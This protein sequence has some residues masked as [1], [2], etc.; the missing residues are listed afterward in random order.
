MVRREPCYLFS[1]ITVSRAHIGGSQLARTVL[2]P[3]SSRMLSDCFII[4]CGRNLH[5]SADFCLITLIIRADGCQGPAA[6]RCA[7]PLTG[8]WT[9][10]T[11]CR[12]FSCI[13]RHHSPHKTCQFPRNRRHCYVSFLS[14]PYQAVIPAPHSCICLIRIGYHFCGIPLLAMP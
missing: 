10:D 6:E 7:A 2:F 4:I 12:F 3:G 8:S 14:M 1:W 5:S 13:F 11:S 9:N